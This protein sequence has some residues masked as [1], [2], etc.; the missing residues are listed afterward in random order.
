M[1]DMILGPGDKTMSKT[2]GLPI[3][4]HSLTLLGQWR[5]CHCRA[6]STSPALAQPE[7]VG[8]DDGGHQ[9]HLTQVTEWLQFPTSHPALS[10][11]YI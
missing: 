10:L 8:L 5:K 7:G 11:S 1:P 3:R 9:K 6:Q 2:Q 4:R